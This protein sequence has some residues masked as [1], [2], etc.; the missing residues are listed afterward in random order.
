MFWNEYISLWKFQIEM[1]SKRAERR[2][3]KQ[4][5]WPIVLWKTQRKSGQ[6]RTKYLG[7]FW[8]NVDEQYRKFPESTTRLKWIELSNDNS[9]WNDSKLRW[10][11]RFRTTKMTYQASK[12]TKECLTNK[13]NNF[14][15]QHK[16]K[17]R[18]KTEKGKWKQRT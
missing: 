11:M 13:S 5:K 4:W 12:T 14:R 7:T 1:Q 8:K 10:K 2:D 6:T 17:N 3:S 9:D 18:H 15:H 16:H